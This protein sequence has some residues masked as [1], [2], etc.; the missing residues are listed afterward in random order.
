M[1]GFYKVFFKVQQKMA[2]ATHT[3]LILAL[4]FDSWVP[5]VKCKSQH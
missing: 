2:S 5:K 3:V 1:N 4:Y